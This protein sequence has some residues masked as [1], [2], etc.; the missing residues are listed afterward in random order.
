MSLP[1]EPVFSLLR[2]DFV[3][4]WQNIAREDFVGS[5]HGYTCEDTA[6]GTTNGAGPRNTQIFVLSPGGVVLHCLPGFWHPDDLAHELEFSKVL[7]R[8]WQDDRPASSKRALYS[9]MQ[10][11][12]PRAHSAAMRA[13][14]GWQGFDASHERARLEHGPRDTFF[15]GQDGQP[16]A[17]KPIDV[18]VHERMAQR[19]FVSF[20][21]FDTDAFID[22]GRP[23]YD[24]NMGVDG[25]GV[26]FGTDGYMASQRR[27]AERRKEREERKARQADAPKPDADSG[28]RERPEK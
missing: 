9:R 12:A 28:P 25:F 3:V 16:A 1:E 13:R 8:L 21:K 22:Y 4:G 20:Q 5:S 14:S 17:L 7:H 2:D 27:M 26:Q 10:L 19:P 24:N 18:L 23:Y 11:A 15:A 6:V